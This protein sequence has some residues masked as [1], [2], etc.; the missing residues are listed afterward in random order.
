M[1]DASATRLNRSGTGHSPEFNCAFGGVNRAHPIRLFA[2]GITLAYSLVLHVLPL[3]AAD[4]TVEIFTQNNRP[5]AGER[6]K[7]NEHSFLPFLVSFGLHVGYDSN[8]R[9]TA[10]G[11]SSFFTDEELTLAYDRTR[12][13]LDL[14][15]LSGAGV[16]ERFGLKTDV[17][18]FLDLS[19]TYRVSPRLTLTGKIDAAYRAEPDF[20]SDVGVT[21]RA[22]NYFTTNNE[23]SAAY[24]W[25][26]RFSTVS[27]YTLRLIRY[28]NSLVAASTDREEHT[29]GEEFR[30]ALFRQTVV[31]ADYRF[32]VVDYDT[33]PRDS[34]THF[35]LVG[36]EQSF[37]SRLQAQLRGGASF[38]S[39]QQGDNQVNPDFEGSLNY[40][41]GR[42]SSLS[43][44]SRYSVEEPSGLQ[45]S[46]SRTTFRTGLQFHYAFTNRISSA[47]GLNYHHDENQAGIPATGVSGFPPDSAFST[48]AYEILLSLR[49]QISRHVDVDVGYQH[50]EVNSSGQTQNVFGQARQY[51]RNRYSLGLN[52]SF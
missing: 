15:I 3:W 41:L 22:G 6:A 10:N 1:G 50:S 46:L 37:S 8:S 44:M 13:P 17:N 36:V 5:A 45:S 27:S 11:S 29:L 18:A 43:L 23:L 4:P 30:L 40:A 21:G 38:R 52:F 28:E 34:L 25:S 32:L 19:L 39:F 12:G 26:R 9:T 20:T 2:L 7:T 35:A 49:Y 16:V 31:V 14:H 33:F 51:S 24:Q 48:D 47:V 42:D